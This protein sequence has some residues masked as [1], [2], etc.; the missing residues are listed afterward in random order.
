MKRLFILLVLSLLPLA[1]FAQ[2]DQHYF[3]YKTGSFDLEMNFAGQKMTTH[4]VFA[5]YGALQYG[6]VSVM[7]QNIKTVLRDGKSYMVAPQFQEVPTETAVNYCNLTPEV[8]EQ[9]GIQMVGLEQMDGYECLVYTLT[10]NV[11]DMEGKGKVWIWEG[12]TIRA[13]VNVMGMK[14]VSVIKNL[15]LDTPVDM[16]LFDLPQK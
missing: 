7:G 13:E 12:F 4:T 1:G 8:I 6:E 5:D 14:V 15:Q 10:M 16:A 11:Q 3:S 9:Y 2:G